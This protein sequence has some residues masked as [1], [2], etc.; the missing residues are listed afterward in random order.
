M[1]SDK[2]INALEGLLKYLNDN[3]IELE[4]CGCCD[5]IIV[6]GEGGWLADF[7]YSMTVSNEGISEY[8]NEHKEAKNEPILRH[9]R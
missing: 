5:G 2:Y 9:A 4:S 8:L 6:D 3:H 1:P 7:T